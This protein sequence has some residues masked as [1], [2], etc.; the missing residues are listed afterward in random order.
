VLTLRSLMVMALL[1]L[2]LGTAACGTISTIQTTAIKLEPIIVPTLPDNIPSYLAVDPDTGL[3]MTGKPSVVDFA[4]Y[5][6]KV[7]GKVDQ[8]L[9]LTYDE[10]R[11]LPKVTATPKLVC[12]GVFVDTAT[13]SGVPLKTILEMAHVQSSA[14]SIRMKSADGYSTAISLEEAL[15]PDNYLAYELAGRTLPILQGFPLRAVIP[16]MNGFAWVKWLTEI[17]AE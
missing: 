2:A 7:T 8:E 4:S 15:D 13:W 3:H 11:L 9:S 16:D 12:Q 1:A 6:L 14:K 5:R 17:S 10:L